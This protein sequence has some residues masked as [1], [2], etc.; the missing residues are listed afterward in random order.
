MLDGEGVRFVAVAAKVRVLIVDD[1][2]VIAN[3]LALIF[4]REG[5]EARAVYSAEEAL[6]VLPEFQPEI[7]ILDVVLPR[8]NG[9]DLAILMNAECPNCDVTLFSGQAI[10][11]ELQAEANTKGHPFKILPKPLH[12]TELLSVAAKKRPRPS[13][14]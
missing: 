8:M 2:K 9:I 14:A 10:T 12:P 11:Q 6:Q 1:E 7:A 3:S 4:N 13:Q 5:Y